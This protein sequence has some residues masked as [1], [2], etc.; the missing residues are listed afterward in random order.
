MTIYNRRNKIFPLYLILLIVMSV[1]LIF[2]TSFY[3]H[4]EP[5]DGDSVETTENGSPDDN[6]S[7]DEKDDDAQSDNDS[8]TSDSDGA[9]STADPDSTESDETTGVDTGNLPNTA[10]TP[11]PAITTL[12]GIVMDI[13][14]GTILY[15]KDAYTKRYPASIT[16]IMTAL[17][18]LEKGDLSDTITM[19]KEAVDNTPSDSSNIALDYDEK[20]NLKDAMY[21]MLLNSAND[22]AYGIAEHIG[23]SLSGFCDMMNAKA[24]ELGCQNTHFS[25]ASGLTAADHY[26]CCYDMALI[27]RAVYAYSEFKDIS[28]TM[29][30]TIP[31][32]NKNTERVLWHGDNML[33]ES[34]DYYY[35]YATCGKTG[36]TTEAHGTLITFAEKDGH[37]LVC[38]LMD[39]LPAST[40]FTESAALLDF[41]FDSFHII[42]PLENFSFEK[43]DESSAMLDNYYHSL[44]HGLPNL[45]TDTSYTLYVRNY[46]TS[47][48]IERT[49]VMNDSSDSEIAGKIV[50]SFEGQTLGEVNI[51]N[52]DYIRPMAPTVKDNTASN[53]KPHFEFHAYYIIIIAIVIILLILLI[54]VN[55]LQKKRMKQRKGESAGS[56]ANKKKHKKSSNKLNDDDPNNSV[57][58]ENEYS[59]GSDINTQDYTYPHKK[60]HSIRMAKKKPLTRTDNNRKKEAE[61]E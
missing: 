61:N 32:T 46:I 25:N 54:E 40:T 42:Q 47:E 12:S 9:D 6:D 10:R 3:V 14:S 43:D 21:A 2:R 24:A 33:F 59:G 15:E 16:K 17:I 55:A 38:V 49:V 19:S 57:N 7:S 29:T 8:E 30:Y 35:A 23:G 28:S 60:Y 1:V 56:S 22:S 20:M 37:R 26:T 48:N 58:S 50:F 34:S 45:S 53:K 13:D 27:G 52:N 41:C 31:A 4:A 51:I 5:E 18:A 36:Y 44:T 39:V 11:A